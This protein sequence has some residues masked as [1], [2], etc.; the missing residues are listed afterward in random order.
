MI[1]RNARAFFKY[2]RWTFYLFSRSAPYEVVSRVF[3]AKRFDRS[4]MKRLPSPT[5]RS[6]FPVAAISNSRWW[7]G[8]PREWEGMFVAIRQVEGISLASEK[9]SN[10]TETSKP[11]WK[12]DGTEREIIRARTWPDVN[13]NDKIFVNIDHILA[14]TTDRCS[15]FVE[16]RTYVRI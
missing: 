2:R 12:F 13:T 14:I 9:S 6:S 7:P 10:Y 1:R 15:F 16:F 8:D 4:W 3:A 11:Q 5:Y